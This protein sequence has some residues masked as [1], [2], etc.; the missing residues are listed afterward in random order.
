MLVLVNTN[1][2]QPPIAPIGLEYVAA[3]AIAADVPVRI[4]DLGLADDPDATLQAGL[5]DTDPVLVGLSFRNADDCFWP[6]AQS[7]VPHL[8]AIIARIRRISDAPVCL[9]GVAFSIFGRSLLERVGADFGIR[10]DGEH[11]LPCLY[12]A[13]LDQHPIQAVPGLVLPHQDHGRVGEPAWP[14]PPDVPTRRDIVDNCSYFARGGQIGFETKRG[15]NRHCTYC[16]DPLAKGRRLRLRDPRQV[17]DEVQAL[18]DRGID[19]LHTCDAEFNLPY[20]HA[21]AVCRAL[22]KRRL[23][24]HVRW[25]AYLAVLP[26]DAELAAAMRRAGCVGIDF[27]SDSAAPAM[28]RAYRQRHGPADLQRA[29]RL[30][31]E[32]GIRVMLDLLLGGPGETPQTVAE[33][34]AFL[35]RIDPD[36]V[37]AACGL[38][39]YP[40]TEV[41][42]ALSR[43]GSLDDLPGLRRRYTGPVDL[44]EPTFYISPALGEDPA[45]LIR[46]HIAGDQRFFP[47]M[48]EAP[49]E[50]TDARTPDDHNYNANAELVE[51]IAAGA[52]GAYW[53]ILSRRRHDESPQVQ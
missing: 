50:T 22:E 23:G 8:Q 31:R 20:E 1:T 49:T 29:V 46:D 25:Y 44:L 48:S 43:Q 26:F 2:M 4:I 40:G 38:R 33:S 32:N 34:I 21:M 15:C 6:S 36:C 52:R 30:C 9:G 37:G 45:A 19:V 27:T 39:L 51:A 3:A 41:T 5:T 24:D 10:G 47:P 17:A 7:F 11:A 18:A 35:K 42:T 13:L 12:R 28:L 16:A 14:D 53:D